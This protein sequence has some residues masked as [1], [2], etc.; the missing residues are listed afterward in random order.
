MDRSEFHSKNQPALDQE[1]T[2]NRFK[3]KLAVISGGASGI[4]YAVAERFLNDGAKVVI[5]DINNDA[6][7]LLGER[8]RNETNCKTLSLFKVDVTDKKN[9]IDV[10]NGIANDNGGKIDALVNSAVYFGSKG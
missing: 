5:L 2:K 1:F 10:I 8:Y 7:K 4:G 3:G 6:L 9:V